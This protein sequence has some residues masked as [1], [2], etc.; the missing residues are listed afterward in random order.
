MTDDTGR[1]PLNRTERVLTAM[2]ASVGGLSL[3]AMIIVMIASMAGE[4]EFG[5][6]WLFLRVLPLVGLPIAVVLIVVFMIVATLRRRR[7]ERDGGR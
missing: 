1:V 6:A 2:I 5:G 4:A 7:I 3:L